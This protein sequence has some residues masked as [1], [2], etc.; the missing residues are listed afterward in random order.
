[1]ISMPKGTCNQGVEWITNQVCLT[2]CGK[3]QAKC[4]CP[5]LPWTIWIVCQEILRGLKNS[6]KK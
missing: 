2:I 1:M 3:T 4:I 5:K 6:Q